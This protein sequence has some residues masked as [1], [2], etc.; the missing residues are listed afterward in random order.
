M[1]DSRS[2]PVSSVQL[3]RSVVSNSLQQTPWAACSTPGFILCHLLLL[4]PST[5]PI[6]RVFFKESGFCIR[7]PKYWS[8]SF[9]ISPSNEYSE[10]ISFRIDWFDLFAVQGTLRSL[11]PHHQSRASILWCSAFFMVQLSHPYMT[12][13]KTVTWTIQTFVV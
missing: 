3:S 8:F 4:P 11:L 13:R 6:I 10:L 5:F 9:S 7:G 12:T 2:S 1:E